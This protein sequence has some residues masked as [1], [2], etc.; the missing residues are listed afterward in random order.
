MS[1]FET[2]LK[3]AAERSVLKII[4][5]GQWVQPDYNNR[6]KLP[7]DFMAGVW[8]LVDTAKLQAALA[9]RLEDELADRIVNHMAAEIATDIKQLLS[10]RER[11]E[12]LRALARQH[13]DSLKPGA[14]Q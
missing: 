6:F 3:E 12:Q 14:Q 4:S 1:D 13:I 9:R 7:A 11:R 10:D 8:G 2:R 5:E